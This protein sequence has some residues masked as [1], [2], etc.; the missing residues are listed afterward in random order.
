MIFIINI[1]HSP[2]LYLQ[3]LQCLKIHIKKI[4]KILLRKVRS[5]RTSVT[6]LMNI[7]LSTIHKVNCILIKGYVDPKRGII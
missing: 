7:I 1:E 4:L 2:V 5:K 6:T 3:T